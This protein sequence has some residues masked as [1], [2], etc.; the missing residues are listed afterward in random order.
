MK[1]TKSENG[2]VTATMPHEIMVRSHP[3][4][5]IPLSDSSAERGRKKGR[6][7]VKVWQIGEEG[8]RGGGLGRRSL[9]GVLLSGP[10]R[11]TVRRISENFTGLYLLALPLPPPLPENRKGNQ[12]NL[13]TTLKYAKLLLCVDQR[14]GGLAR[15]LND[16]QGTHHRRLRPPGV[17]RNSLRRRP[18]QSG[19]AVG[20]VNHLAVRG[21]VDPHRHLAMDGKE[22]K[23]AF[24][25]LART[26]A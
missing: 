17:L 26:D 19:A 15:R 1:Q 16:T 4:R 25:F 2:S 22:D 23:Q 7:S 14:E 10:S 20:A 21:N 11:V 5:P 6:S 3:Q 8:E 13:L 24:H 9:V 18:R 12:S